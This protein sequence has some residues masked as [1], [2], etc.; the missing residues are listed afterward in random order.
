MRKS[1]ELKAEAEQIYLTKAKP[2]FDKVAAEKRSPTQDER[3]AIDGFEKQMDQLLADAKRYEKFE[4]RAIGRATPNPQDITLRSTEEQEQPEGE[5]QRAVVKVFPTLGHQLAA[6]MRASSGMA[7]DDDLNRLRA[8][9][10]GAGEA[11][12]SD[13]GWLV[14]SDFTQDIEK[15]MFAVGAILAL[16]NP[17]TVG[18]NRLVERFIDETSRATGSRWGSV[19]GYW[20]AEGDSLTS[21]KI[22]IDSMKTELEKVAAVGYASN[23]L[24]EDAPAMSSLYTTAFAEE[25]IFLTEDG[26][27]EGDG[28]GKPL[29]ILNA[30]CTISQ[31][32]E[33]S[34]TA[35][36]VVLNNLSKMWS[37]M[38][39]RSK[40]NS[41][42]LINNEVNPQLD[43]LSLPVTVG[44]AGGPLEAR[45]VT[46]DQT[47][48]TRIKGR[49][50]V[51]VEYCAALGT[52]GD[53]VLADFSQYRLIS[54]ANG[55]QQ[56][57]SMH[58]KFSTDEMT[59]RATYRVG[60]QPKWKS[61]ITPFK[62]TTTVSPF[63]KLAAR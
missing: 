8:V 16:C 32:A 52:S 63:V 36:T 11:V 24:L 53:I 31:A 40:A 59:F 54:K 43:I 55:V 48:V 15:R 6:I 17:I 20:V 44:S 13:G 28:N 46:I 56:A 9:A 5:R 21:S 29:G 4:D 57:Q 25:L 27:F 34:Q 51:E 37:R 35:A 14:Q 22:K 42:W 39:T 47:G 19:R 38:H 18:G 1:L 10:T 33:G 50:V 45:F 2:I 60:G 30:N 62:G 61:A 23:E 12:E 3:D 26:I 7:K 41:Y 49:P 58:V